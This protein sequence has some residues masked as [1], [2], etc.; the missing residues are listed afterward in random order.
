MMKLRYD[1]S[2]KRFWQRSTLLPLLILIVALLLMAYVLPKM[3]ERMFLLSIGI[4]IGGIIAF[5]LG[6]KSFFGVFATMVLVSF[7]QGVLLLAL[8]I[9][10]DPGLIKYPLLVAGFAL[11]LARRLVIGRIRV[12]RAMMGYLVAILI[13]Y[14]VLV[15]TVI[16]AMPPLEDIPEVLSYWSVLNIPLVI[17]V[18]MDLGDTKPVYRFM[19]I[20]VLSGCLAVLFGIAQYV[21]G[22]ERLQGMGF[23]LS[24]NRFA[25]FLGEDNPSSFRAFSFFPSYYEYASFVTVCIVAQIVL[26]YRSTR[27]HA[28]QNTAILLLLIIGLLSTFHISSWLSALLAV[29]IM[30]LGLSH[31]GLGILRSKR[32]WRRMAPTMF[33]GTIALLLVPPI[34]ERILGIFMFE[35]GVA[36]AA[37]ASLWWRIRIV[38]TSLELIREFPFG[39]GISTQLRAPVLASLLAQRGWFLITSDAFFVWQ[40]LTGGILLFVAFMVVLVLP[41]FTAFR[42]RHS[43]R[44]GDRPLFWGIW[45]I[46]TVGV[47][48]GGISN[49]ALLNGTPSNLIVW[50]S[51]GVLYRLLAWKRPLSFD[52]HNADA[53]T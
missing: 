23:D 6:Y 22:P 1:S 41:I 21:L 34:R 4:T 31:R 28:V 52:K 25:F 7:F 43:I 3:S 30:G 32:L 36:G 37:G 46:L 29:G 16:S 10:I 17:L 9:P 42:F 19:R 45:S 26:I 12:S 20:M 50:A 8:R 38:T 44:R 2:S 53:P 18:Y 11:L 48:A 39:I 14:V 47:I 35:P 40:A 13:Y 27:H 51:I 33:F 15:G 49:S 5:G 24:L